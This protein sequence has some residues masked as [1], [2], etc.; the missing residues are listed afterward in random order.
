MKFKLKPYN[1]HELGQRDNQEDALFPALGQSTANDRLF[2]LCDGMGGHEGGEVA[3]NAVCEAMSDVILS[4]WNPQEPLPENLLLQA[5][6]AA[7]DALD[8]SDNGMERKMGTTM[9]F[10]CFH[11]DGA[12]VAHIGDSRVYQIRPAHGQ[13]K[14]QILFKTRD[15]SL[16][17][18][19]IKVGEIT[20]EEAKN[21]P[22]KNVITRAMQPMQ[23]RRAKADIAHITDI[24]PGDY[25]YM[26]S[27]GMLEQTTDENLRFIIAESEFVDEEKIATLIDVTKD[28]H[29]NHT[30]HLIHVLDVQGA[31]VAIP[32]SNAQPRPYSPGAVAAPVSPSQRRPASN[33]E[34]MQ[35]SIQ[36]EESK[37]KMLYSAFVGVFLIL[38]FAAGSFFRGAS[39]E[40]GEEKQDTPTEKPQKQ[41]KA[42]ENIPVAEPVQPQTSQQVTT[43]VPTPAASTSSPASTPSKPKTVTASAK[44]VGKKAGPTENVDK[45]N[46][47][48]KSL[49]KLKETL[50]G[51]T[52]NKEQKDVVIDEKKE[53]KGNA[54]GAANPESPQKDVEEGKDNQK[55]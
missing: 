47:D 37:K 45:G 34:Q 28:N 10:L 30:A 41:D 55:K 50:D 7:Y 54:T 4:G 32:A 42:S 19:L 27:D 12:T 52:L 26:C 36:R 49:E 14:A 2:I 25:F 23:E 13:E 21:H 29:D 18:D 24:Q 39:S 48:D 33:S 11:A 35:K 15:H 31:P 1:I 53:D 20:E 17:N 40:K 9:T 38:A 3:S 16:V 5:L 43:P 46:N 8:Q 44:E 6:N 22:Q 51:K